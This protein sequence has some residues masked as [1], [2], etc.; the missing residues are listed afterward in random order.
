MV[1]MLAT[2]MSLLLGLTS[3]TLG[4]RS[5]KQYDQ[6]FIS[7]GMSDVQV[8]SAK[9]SLYIRFERWH[10][11]RPIFPRYTLTWWGVDFIILREVEFARRNNVHFSCGEITNMYAPK[12]GNPDHGHSVQIPGFYA[13]ARFDWSFLSALA[14]ASAIA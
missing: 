10:W 2:A 1:A 11:V 3:S 9:G 13:E 12:D 8:V 14:T 4:V 5:E 7:R 6:V